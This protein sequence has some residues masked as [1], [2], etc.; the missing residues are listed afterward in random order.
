MYSLEFSAKIG[1]QR[2]PQDE[3]ASTVGLAALGWK[4]LVAFERKEA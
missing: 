1:A 3:A 2:C 4:S